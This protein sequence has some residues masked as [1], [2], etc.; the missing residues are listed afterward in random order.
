LTWSL[1]VKSPGLSAT[2]LIFCFIELADEVLI[3]SCSMVVRRYFGWHGA[4]A[5]FLIAALGALV[6]PA[7]FVVENC[8]HQVSERRILKVGNTH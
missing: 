2:L 6:L 4:A 3:S 5:G 8:S 7:N 1:F